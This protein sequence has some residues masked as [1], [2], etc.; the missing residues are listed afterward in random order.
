VDVGGPRLRARRRP[1]PQVGWSALGNHAARR[2]LA[3]S[4]ETLCVS[5][6]G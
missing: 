6:A 2:S 4:N 3:R 1:Q 5:W